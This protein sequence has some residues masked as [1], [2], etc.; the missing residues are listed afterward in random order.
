MI[1]QTISHYKILEKLGEG[2]MGVVYKAEDTKL[3]RT[4]A[5]KFLPSHV[6]IVDET[7]ARFLQEAKAAAALNHPNICTIYGVEENAE[8][9]FIAMEFVEGGTLTSKIPF[10]N[11]DN[12]LTVAMQIGEALQEAHAKG[13]VHRDIKADNIMLTAKGQVKVMDFGL[14]K[15][16]GSLK[17]TRT[18]STVGTLAY[19]A[20]EQ[21]QGGEVDARSDIFS[22]G[23]LLFEMLTGKTPFR[24]EHEA[25]MVYSIVN[26]D[27]QAIDQ[28]IPDLS[29]VIVNLIQRCLEKDPNDRYQHFDD[30]VADLGRAKKK[31][32]RVMR[33]T[34]GMPV[35][36]TSERRTSG[37]VSQP[38]L[39]TIARRER[40]PIAVYIA[41]GV[42]VIV[43]G[44]AAWFFFAKSGIAVNPDM[45]ANVLQIPFT[46]Y[47][48]P[49]ISPDGKWLAFP[50]AD[51]N[52]KW[53]IYYMHV[54]G[55]EPRKITNDATSIT[56]Q[57]ATISPDGGS[58]VYNKPSDDGKTYDLFSISALGG[59]S[60]FLADRASVGRWRPD[61]KRVGFVRIPIPQLQSNSGMIEFWTVGA[62]GSD[63]RREFI[64]SLFFIKNTNYRYSFCWAPDGNSVGWVRTL[65][66]LKQEI[67]VHSLTTGKE[68]QV[69]KGDENID[70]LAWTK[71]DRI[72]YSSNR[73]GNTNL[74]AI[75]ASGGEA[76][77][78]T[79]G[80]GPDVGISVA[81]SGNELL[82]LQQQRVGHIWRANIDGSGIHQ[83]TFDDRQ[84]LGAVLSP[85]KKLIAFVMNDPDPLKATSD[86]YV[87]D[88]DGN[89]RRRLTEGLSRP[90]NPE[91]SPD[92]KRIAFTIPPKIQ[93]TDSSYASIYVV[94]V[95]HPGTPRY[96][97]L[98]F[99][100]GWMDNDHILSI[101]PA[102]PRSYLNT[103][104][105]ATNRKFLDDS[106]FVWKIIDGKRIAYYDLHAAKRGW[107]VVDI[108]PTPI[109]ELMKQPD[110]VVMP[111]VRGNAKKAS[112]AP[113]PWHYWTTFATNA[114]KVYEI[115]NPGE[116]REISFTGEKERILKDRFPGLLDFGLDVSK[117]GKEVVFVEP[118]LSSQL[119]LLRDVFQ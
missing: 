114:E 103:I 7:K 19:M 51:A 21:I 102:N 40:N 47:S 55:G 104:S 110:D 63:I 1:G 61:G 115:V 87:M 70:D 98:G 27:P 100:T 88:R 10:T 58:I 99:V 73:G 91:W 77:Q 45:K 79:K 9:M 36:Q 86:V 38:T 13:I 6:S 75:P 119:V 59:T 82:Y 97:G 72:I 44:L 11:V 52:G 69:T 108:Q 78:I 112:S 83:L 65:S 35:Q 116:V 43:V 105:T 3:D 111:V 20:P 29:P 106:T 37:F 49:G 95:G 17:L 68:R 66:S 33:S 56:N 80:A 28:F 39:P 32:D 74:W 101:S 24:G 67:I 42:A 31:T 89:N 18:S 30:I 96:G 92:G 50:A 107:W 46:Q 76:V 5:L 23:V 57:T 12:A 81:A 25:A 22:F 71:D 90:Q 16:K 15:L 62:D 113:D 2:G 54:G 84:I 26:E 60:R 48:Y 8:T 34:V 117:D 94:D 41:I 14:A 93:G 118:R 64:D 4:V 53:D 85:D 109:E